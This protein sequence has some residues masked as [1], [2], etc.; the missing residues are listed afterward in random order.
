M[1]ARE[2][3]AGIGMVLPDVQMSTR[4]VFHLLRTPLYCSLAERACTQ[5]YGP[6]HWPPIRGILDNDHV[7]CDNQ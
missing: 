2:I 4:L 1:S 6:L 3:P 7:I 5:K